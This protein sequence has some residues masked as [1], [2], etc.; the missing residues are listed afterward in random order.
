MNELSNK[1][2]I[3]T[4]GARGI[5]FG[6]CE[7]LGAA[8]CELV[9]ADIDEEKSHA[10]VGSLRQAGY[11][12]ET[13]KLD[14]TREDSVREMVHGCMEL[15]GRIDILVNCSGVA[16]NVVSTIHLTLAEW[17]RV[18]GVNLSGLFLC[19]REV[20]MVMARQG[21]GRIINIASLNSVSPAAL[22]AAYNVSK[23][24]VVSLTQTLAVELAPFGVNVN[25][26]SPGPIETEFHSVVMPQRA[27]T[28][29]I[30]REQM[31]ERIRAAIPLGRWGRPSDIGKAVC[32]LASSQ[33]DWITAQNLIVSGGLSGVS[34]S[35]PK[36]IV[37]RAS[38]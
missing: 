19:C 16:P 2:A 3:V 29:G 6:V 17:N 38:E 34:A 22:T 21:G 33:S 18:L 12:C 15:H 36:E 4:G 25:A 11:R 37:F 5:G 7:A 23:A 30:S 8:G 14:V 28:L 1:I 32:F 26:V 20:G 24:G 13:Q 31:V 35:P 9:I 27:A 10:A